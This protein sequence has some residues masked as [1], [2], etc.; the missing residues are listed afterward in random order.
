[1]CIRD[2]TTLYAIDVDKYIFLQKDQKLAGAEFALYLSEED[3]KAGENAIATGKT[4][5]DGS[6][7]QA[8]AGLNAGTYYLVETKAPDGYKLAGGVKD[9][10][11]ADD[12]EA[13]D[14][15]VYTAE[16][17]S[18]TH[19]DVYKRQELDRSVSTG[20]N[21]RRRPSGSDPLQYPHLSQGYDGRL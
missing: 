16:A 15:F 2:R 20:Q 5:K 9:I 4:E 18:Y 3:A 12:I 13:E 21:D 17:V 10:T 6:L 7:E 8:F 19:L 1:M 14:T 11:L